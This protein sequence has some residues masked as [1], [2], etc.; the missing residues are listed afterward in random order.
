MSLQWL[1]GQCAPE[2]VDGCLTATH[3][4]LLALPVSLVVDQDAGITDGMLGPA[5][6]GGALRPYRRVLEC[7]MCA[8]STLDPACW[9]GRWD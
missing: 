6:V 2:A 1:Q 8:P 9:S 7:K 5:Q 3:A 4:V